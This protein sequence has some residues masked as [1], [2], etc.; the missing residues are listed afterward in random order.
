[1]QGHTQDFVN[2]ITS[3]WAALAAERRR[4]RHPGD[5]EN[6]VAVLEQIAATIVASMERIERRM[7]GFDHRMESIER[8]LDLFDRRMDSFDR[9]RD[10]LGARHHNDFKWI[11]SIMFA[12]FSATL[13]GFATML[14]V[15]AHG[16]HWL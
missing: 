2:R 5:M 13:A 9:R 8:R 7:D 14:G 16:F 12:G 4:A 10:M 11:L 6:R 15:M 3:S 1:V